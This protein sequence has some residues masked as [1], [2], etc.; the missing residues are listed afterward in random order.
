MLNPHPAKLPF[1]VF[2]CALAL[3]LALGCVS[4]KQQKKIHP[5]PEPGGSA[6]IQEINLLAIP[7]ALNFDDKP[8]P[9]GFVIKIYAG[10]RN[11][12]KPFPIESGK[13]EVLMYD[14]IP[15]VTENAA[16]KPRRVWTY[17]AEELRQSQIQSSVGTGYQLAPLWG[18]AKPVQ[19]KIA[20]VVRYT[21][22]N[23]PPITSAPSVIATR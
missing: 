14:G 6:A 3:G 4:E 8:G 21:P 19:N 20:V 16:L 7:V 15:G 18:D 11:R 17:T 2:W 5:K 22:L 1:A 13:I 9:D 10:N 12:A 23:G